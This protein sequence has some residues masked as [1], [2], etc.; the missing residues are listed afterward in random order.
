MFS[1]FHEDEVNFDSSYDKERDSNQVLHP[2]ELFEKEFDTDQ[3]I[4]GNRFH[5]TSCDL[6][7]NNFLE[8]EEDTTYVQSDLRCNDL[9]NKEKSDSTYS[10]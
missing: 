9:A 10:S 8:C 7:S 2:S 6:G 3:Y 5:D 4:L 1:Y